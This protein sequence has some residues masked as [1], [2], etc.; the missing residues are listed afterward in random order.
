M[1]CLESWRSS[2]MVAPLPQGVLLFM[3]VDPTQ[4][5]TTFET[6]AKEKVNHATPE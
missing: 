4:V 1:G 6:P 5:P 2:I 3:F